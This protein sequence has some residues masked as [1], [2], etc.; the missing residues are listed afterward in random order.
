MSMSI[1]APADVS[2][3]LRRLRRLR[4][5][6]LRLLLLLL[7]PEVLQP[8]HLDEVPPPELG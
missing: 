5:L 6:L 1:L 7:Q 4:L 2:R 8:T 3:L